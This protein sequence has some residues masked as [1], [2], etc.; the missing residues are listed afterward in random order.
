MYKR[1][2]NATRTQMAS[3]R[4]GS[5]VLRYGSD[6]PEAE[7]ARVALIAARAEDTIRKLVESAPAPTP[8]QID[9]LRRLLPPVVAA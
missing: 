2:P 4:L 1:K 5:I 7:A 6:S 8:E 9:R 3:G